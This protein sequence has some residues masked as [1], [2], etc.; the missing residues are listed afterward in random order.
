MEERGK[1][2]DGEIGKG[3]PGE[4]RGRSRGDRATEKWGGRQRGREAGDRECGR[5]LRGRGAVI[6]PNDRG[7]TV[8]LGLW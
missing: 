6:C 7:S 3:I 4:E 1:Q 8:C 5:Q 2:E